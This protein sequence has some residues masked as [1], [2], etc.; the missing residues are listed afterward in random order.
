MNIPNIIPTIFCKKEKILQI[1]NFDKNFDQDTDHNDK[2][3]GW[4]RIKVGAMGAK[5][6]TPMM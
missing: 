2:V 5:I 4:L 6:A 3:N 1:N